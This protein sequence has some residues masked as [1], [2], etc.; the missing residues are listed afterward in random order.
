MIPMAPRH[1]QRR[2]QRGSGGGRADNGRRTIINGGAVAW[3]GGAGTTCRAAGPA[4]A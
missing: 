4:Q 2:R 1:L 3:R